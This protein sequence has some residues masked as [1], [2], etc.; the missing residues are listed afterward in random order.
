LRWSREDFRLRGGDDFVRLDGL[1]LELLQDF[2]GWLQ[3]PANG[4]RSPQEASALA[5][6]ADRYVRDFLVDFLESGPG[7][8]A[9]RRVRQYVGNW[10][11]VQTLEPSHAEVETILHALEL[12]YAFLPRRGLLEEAEAERFRKALSE[13]AFFHRRL[14]DFWELTPEGIPGWREVDDY[15]PDLPARSQVL[16]GV[17]SG[18]GTR[19]PRGA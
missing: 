10:Y 3:E 8:P 6:A 12:F 1:C 14:E 9:E 18:P 7:D 15:R 16:A 4:P 5:H 17:L 19:D 13:R 2:F 11:V